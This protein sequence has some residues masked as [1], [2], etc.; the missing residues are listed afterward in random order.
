MAMLGGLHIKM[1]LLKCI[2]DLL[3]RRSW[4]S[5]ISQANIAT[6]GTAESF[7]KDS[8][9]KKT[10]RDNQVTACVQY[11][12]RQ[13]SYTKDGTEIS[14]ANWSKEQSA[15]SVECKFWKP[16]LKMELTLLTWDEPSTRGIFHCMWRH[17]QL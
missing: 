4:T 5:A 2:G 9:V 8:R 13:Y 14:R 1:T 17:Y 11:T 3:T 15:S 10:A 12:L 7:R 6:P 16:I